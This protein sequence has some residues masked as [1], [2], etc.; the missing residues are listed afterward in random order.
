MADT[1]NPQKYLKFLLNHPVYYYP[2]PSACWFRRR[3]LESILAD[4][5]CRVIL[6]LMSLFQDISPV[7]IY[8]ST[9][10]YIIV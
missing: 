5:T 3:G 7:D 2:F 4:E 10:Y 8:M 9:G 1:N 6:D